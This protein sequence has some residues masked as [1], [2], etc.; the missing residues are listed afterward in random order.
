M[1]V[2]MKLVISS[3]L[4]AL[5]A[6]VSVSAQTTAAPATSAAPEAVTPAQEEHMAA[7][8]AGEGSMAHETKHKNTMLRKNTTKRKNTTQLTKIE[9]GRKCGPFFYLKMSF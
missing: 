7:P 3:L 4:L 6:S 9:K 8:A 5:L 1:E 2:F